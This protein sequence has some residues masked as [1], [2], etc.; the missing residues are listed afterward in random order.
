MPT[1][2]DD[3]SNE[4]KFQ[5]LIAL[6]KETMESARVP[7][8][9][10]GLLAGGEEYVAGLGVTSLTNPLPVTP[11]T[12]FQ[13]GSTTKTFTATLI[14]Q[15][16]E[17]GKLALDD[18]V[19]QHLPGFK[20]ADES[21]AAG[22]TL[23]HLLT[24]TA[25][26]VGDFFP[27]TGWG[28]DAREKYIPLM[29]DLP[30]K[31]PL[32]AFYCYN[33]AALVVAGRIVEVVTGQVYEDAIRQRI[34]EPLGMT[35]SFFFPG[36]VMTRRFAAGHFRMGDEVVVAETWP[37]RRFAN[38]A[39]GVTTD[40]HDQLKYA[41]FHMGDPRKGGDGMTPKGERLLTASSLQQM[42]TPHIPMGEGGWMGLTWMIEE[43]DGVRFYAHGGTTMGQE[44]D[45]W[46][47]PGEGLALAVV[48]NLD[49][50]N[51]VHEALRTWVRE[52]Y[53]GVVKTPPATYTLPEEALAEYAAAFETSTGDLLEFRP[54]QGGLIS[55][56][57]LVPGT[58]RDEDATPH[59]ER[60]EP[61]ETGEPPQSTRDAD[62]TIPPM[63]LRFFATDRFL[64]LDP[65]FQAERGE[66]LRRPDGKI[67]WM[68][69]NGRI[70]PITQRTQG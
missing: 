47:A 19:R 69:F 1:P 66:F 57:V 48:T 64:F 14:M 27:D 31:T 24:H 67:G 9:A 52:H 2:K 44:S 39:G 29:G 59:S 28:D 23:R 13:I 55:K 61:G 41:R 38:P 54:H 51:R 26:W 37:I 63:R 20:V 5:D 46:F 45:F 8:V 62:A 42:R 21:A 35:N 6:T 70:L 60:E 68:R 12:L 30:Q 56:H 25:G 11:E 33:N 36:E 43:I 32:G 50:G 7:G 34:F 40:L 18:Q 10:V 4:A 49:Q 58:L 3:R 15:L 65:P 17:E 53:L 22:V 16:V